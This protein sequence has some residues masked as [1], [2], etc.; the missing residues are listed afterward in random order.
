MWVED[1]QQVHSPFACSAIGWLERGHPYCVGVTPT[2]VLTRL[3]EMLQN[4]VWGLFA[5]GYHH[6]DLENC[7][8]RLRASSLLG[9]IPLPFPLGRSAEVRREAARVSEQ[10]ALVRRTVARHRRRHGWPDLPSESVAP[11]EKR[12]VRY[13]LRL[14]R[15]QA[16]DM[17]AT[18]VWRCHRAAM[19]SV[20]PR[21]YQQRWGATHIEVGAVDLLIPGSTQVYLAPSMVLHYACRHRYRPPDG[22]CEAVLGCPVIGSREY[23]EALRPAVQV[24]ETSDFDTWVDQ[25]LTLIAAIRKK[26]ERRLA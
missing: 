23:F 20:D 18:A 25:Q 1:G 8:I 2:P 7:G 14:L 19:N 9:R 15:A 10:H 4:R 21:P 6:C 11:V 24:L 5:M 17:L 22:F 12:S 3:A 16:V 13:R 26:R